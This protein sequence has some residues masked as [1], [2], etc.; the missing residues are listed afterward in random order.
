MNEKYESIVAMLA[1]MSMSKDKQ[2][3]GLNVRSTSEGSMLAGRSGGDNRSERN[4][5]DTMMNHKV[6]KIDFPQFGRENLREWV[7]KTNKYFQLHQIPEELKVGIAEMYLKGKTD[8]WFH[9]FLFSHPD[10]N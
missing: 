8:V 9:G 1:K 5:N 6:P 4:G 3:E 10:A 7:R 2:V